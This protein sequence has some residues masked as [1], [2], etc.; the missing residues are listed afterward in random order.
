MVQ[1][2]YNYIR[3]AWKKPTT[4]YL[5]DLRWER[6]QKWRRES[7]IIRIERPTRI[8]RARSL[9]YKSK[10]G[11]II[12]RAKIRRGGLKKSR[13]IRGRRTHNMGKNKITQGKSIQRIAEERTSKKYPNLEVLNSYW[14]G[15]DGKYKWYEIILIDPMNS[16]I[17]NDKNLNWICKNSNKGR[18]FRGIT[19][20]GKKGRGLYIRGNGSEKNRPSLRKH[21]NIGK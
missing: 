10:Q 15:Q 19:S 5:F 14:V 11:I 20:S 6:L 17:K 18:A 21:N 9:G 12:V 2:Y 4:S 3:N 13:Y 7:S 16:V 8:D 1:S